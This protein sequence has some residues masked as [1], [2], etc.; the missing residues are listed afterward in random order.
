M[1]ADT[2]NQLP[3][4]KP[5]NYNR[6]DYTLFLRYLRAGG[7]LQVPR[8]NIPNGKTDFNGGGDLSHNFLGSITKI[9]TDRM[10]DGTLL[11]HEHGN[12]TRG[13]CIFLRTDQK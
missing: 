12:S 3:I 1:T 8:S 10:P 7:K 4:T 5:A 6:A 11:G 9:P 2:A 13:S